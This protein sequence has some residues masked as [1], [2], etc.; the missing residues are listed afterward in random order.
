LN[1]AELG[2]DLRDRD[3][4]RHI[5]LPQRLTHRPVAVQFSCRRRSSAGF[6]ASDFILYMNG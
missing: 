4:K 6:N 5:N 2:T 1:I 3:S